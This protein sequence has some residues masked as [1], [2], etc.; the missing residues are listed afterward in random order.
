MTHSDRL[1]AGGWLLPALVVFLL[2]S[3]TLVPTAAAQQE[4]PDG[5][6]KER[7]VVGLV[8][9]GGG[10]KG[11]AH[12][13][14]LRVLEEIQV[15]VDLVVGTSAGA[16]VGA[17]YAQGMPVEEIENRMLEMDWLSSFQDTPGRSYQPVRR[18]EDGWRFPAS[19]GLGVGLDG[20]RVGRGLIS[21]QNLGLILNE[22]TYEAALV[23][24]FDQL[25]IPFR[26]VATDLETGEEVVLEDGS[27]SEAIR[28][29]MS[30]P[31]VYA[32][33]SR[34]GR[35]LVDGGVANN[36]PV[37]VA[38]ELGAEVV[39]V[40]D[41][42]DEPGRGETLTQAF[43][44]LQQ[45]TTLMTRRSVEEQLASLREKDVLITPDL[46]GLSSADFFQGAEL[47]ELGATA[48]REQASALNRLAAEGEQWQQEMAMRTYRGFEPEIIS[49]VVIRQDS[50]LADRFLRDRI[51]QQEGEPLDQ[52]QLEEDLKR[53]YGLGYYENVS[54]SL[55]P[56]GNGG[57]GSVLEIQVREKSWGPNY[58]SFG[59]GYEDNFESNTRFNVA[60][61]LRMTQLNRLGAEWQTGLQLGTQ[62]WV[63]TEWFQP[64]DYGYRRFAVVGAE[65]EKD[66]YS[67]FGE[68]GDRVAE[69]DVSSR[70]LDL[71]LGTEL[72][73][74]AEL[75]ATVER[76]YA[77][78]DDRVGSSPA[79]GDRIQQGSWNL[80]LVYDSLDDP[81]LPESG[82]FAGIRG[83]FER[84]ELGADSEFD[85]TVVRLAK[86]GH[87]GDW[88]AS[89]EF[90][91]SVVTDGEAGIEN[92]VLLGG[93]RRL[94]AYGQGEVTGQD[95]MLGTA[96]LYHKF[97]GPVVPF[98]A[99]A[100]VEAGNAW[101]DI[102]EARW[103]DVLTSGTLFAG[104]DTVIG[105][106]QASLAY[107]NDDRWGVYLNVGYSLRQLFD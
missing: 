76:G 25:P 105:P 74:N 61:S 72:G 65:Y 42:S 102:G 83:R 8:L 81:F 89:G 58:L 26:A 40:V 2:C 3:L 38:R 37:S 43:S 103:D 47:M 86:A 30:I 6:R 50:R 17:L 4:A 73:A 52:E 71:A 57:E 5:A 23:R 66:R 19:P 13:G 95:A 100:G 55:S 78:V 90:F 46:S 63:R 96:V 68:G 48:A 62:P 75:R 94:S 21:G 85:R 79:T 51:R 45:L 36:L 88:V 98:F 64:L 67:V 12:V 15:P 84:P 77:R 106:V 41:I 20:F 18:K 28:A 31:G 70:R 91:A 80:R 35:L 92:N 22:L 10:A 97:G 16:A 54:Y 82:S 53:I 32:P 1:P 27:L 99:G 14:V 24:D 56:G 44:V 9:S 104:F 29:S 39:I 101:E 7:P 93:F 59:L 34:D 87:Q 60:A 33:V 49:Q 69:V 107:N 11:L